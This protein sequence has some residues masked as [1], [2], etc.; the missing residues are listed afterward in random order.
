MKDEVIELLTPGL[1]EKYRRWRPRFTTLQ[2]VA[3][4]LPIAGQGLAIWDA[5]QY[6]P[7]YHSVC[8]LLLVAGIIVWVCA[9][10]AEKRMTRGVSTMGALFASKTRMLLS[11]LWAVASV[12]TYATINTIYS[13]W[14]PPP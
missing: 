1:L 3:V 13:P 8:F 9:A 10:I 5:Q 6:F 2:A 11:G 12:T 4:S 14:T 7:E